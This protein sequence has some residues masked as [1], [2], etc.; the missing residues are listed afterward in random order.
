MSAVGNMTLAIS[1]GLNAG[2]LSGIVAASFGQGP[3]P[4]LVAGASTGGA[5]LTL[6]LT[7]MT[8]IGCFSTSRLS[9]HSPAKVEAA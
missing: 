4:S 2:L 8:L 6:V 7:I 9:K 1:F 3:W 5:V